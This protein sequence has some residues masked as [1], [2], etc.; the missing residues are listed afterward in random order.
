MRRHHSYCCRLWPAHSIFVLLTTGGGNF[1]IVTNFEFKLHEVWP[2]V[3]AGPIVY[4]LEEGV[5]VLKALNDNQKTNSE[6]LAV[7]ACIRQAPPFPFLPDTRQ[8]ARIS[9]TEMQLSSCQI[10]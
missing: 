3:T 8:Y 6:D 10:W 9:P 2:M 5:R 4:S 1:G 7:W